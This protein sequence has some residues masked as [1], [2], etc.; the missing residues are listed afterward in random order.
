MAVKPEA[1][2]AWYDAHRRELPWRA[3][4][5]ERAGP[6][7]VWLSEIM[8]QQTVAAA[9]G[10][11]F[12][13]FVERWPDVGALAAASLDEVLQAW[14]G[15]GYYARA[16]NLHRRGADGLHGVRFPAGRDRIEEA[17]SVRARRH[18]HHRLWPTARM[19][20]GP[21]RATRPRRVGVSGNGTGS[22]S[23]ALGR[24]PV[25]AK[26]SSRGPT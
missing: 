25:S 12:L 15:L 14:Q 6:Y 16:R 2:L 21:E 11:Y 17:R 13:R 8:L 4:P 22:P 3:P 26:T 18:R 24:S 23:G 1:L 10:P 20:R 7:R 5:G 19:G 9:A